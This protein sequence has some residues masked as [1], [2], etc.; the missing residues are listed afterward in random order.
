METTFRNRAMQ[1]TLKIGLAGLGLLL[2]HTPSAKAQECCPDQYTA[3]ELAKVENSASKPVKRAANN[4]KQTTAVLVAKLDPSV[5]A[6][7]KAS[8][9][10]KSKSTA[11]PVAL[12]QPMKNSGE[13]E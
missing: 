2:W 6:G 12:K 8:R 3:A 4:D 9:K 13:Q 11:R 7:T 5:P 10:E 1:L